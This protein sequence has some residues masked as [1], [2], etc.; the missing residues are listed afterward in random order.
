[1]RTP[2]PAATVI[3]FT[4]TA[5]LSLL[6]GALCP[7]GEK[8][9]GV[10][11]VRPAR[12]LLDNFYNHETRDGKRYHYTWDDKASSGFSKLGALFTAETGT[13]LDHL[14]VA[15]TKANL[16]EAAV[17]II[18]DPDNEKE[19]DNHAPHYVDAS[20]AEAVTRWVEA[21]GTLVLMNNAKDEADREHINLLAERFGIT[22]NNDLRN[23]TPNNNRQLA[24][25]DS[26]AAAHAIFREVPSVY[27][28]EICTL[29]VR[30][31]AMAI[32]SAPKE[33][34]EGTDVIMAISQLGRG[35]VFAV[36]DPWLYN[37]YINT[38]VEGRN[39]ANPRAAANLV[40]W[41]LSQPAAAQ[42]LTP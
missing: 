17:Y 9:A 11:E 4:Q 27:L 42:L 7:A 5:A 14:T 23:Q 2:N 33:P 10:S 40:R 30:P 12:I 13:T 15:P 8:Q 39:V 25:V 38:Q 18:V 34:G 37:E 16:R 6:V 26:H 21:G 41:L 3:K 29:T 22:F 35:R 36:G 1:M 24:T 28:K 20:A 31:P 32:L 19:A